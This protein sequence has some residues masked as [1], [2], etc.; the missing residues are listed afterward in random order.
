MLCVVE[1]AHW[2]DSASADALLFCARRLGADRVL[3]VFSARDGA[4]TP[5]RPEGVDELQLVGLDPDAARQLLDERLGDAPAPEVTE[6]LIAESGGNPLALLELP[7]ELSADQLAGSSPLPDTAAPHRPRGAGVPRP[8]QAAAAAGAVDAAARGR[9]RHRQTSPSCAAR[10]RPSAWAS[11]PS[12]RPWP[13]ASSSPT[14][15]RSG[16]VTRWCV[17]PSTRP[18]PESSDARRTA[19]WPTPLAELGDPDREA[20]HRAAAAEGPDP[21][22]VAALERVGSRAESRGGYVSALAAYERAAAL[23]TA[24]PAT[25]RADAGGGPQRLGLRADRSQARAL[26]AAARQLAE[27]PVLLSDIARLQGRIEV[28]IGSANDAHRIFTEAAHA[29][30]DIDPARALEM[31]VAAAIM[32]HLRRRRRRS[33]APDDI[34]T[35]VTEPTP[36]GPRASS[37]CSS[38]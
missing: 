35:A 32:A 18:P 1:D 6:R 17:R 10:R 19:R 2:L 26:L 27:D 9:R 7:T 24:H 34:D 15:S 22:V 8:Q 11:R 31:A 4:A 25:G 30:H 21:E 12:R 36:P 13:P 16:C 37:R 14:P 28:N 23:T 38:R 5:F 29:V 33:L 3:L 20:W